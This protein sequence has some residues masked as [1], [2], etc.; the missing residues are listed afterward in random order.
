MSDRYL[1]RRDVERDTGL[2]RATIYR[3]MEA[4]LFPRPR[5]VGP[6][7]VRWLESDLQRWKAKHP[8]TEPR[9]G[10]HPHP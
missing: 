5:R 4:G 6:N 9:S 3:H 10:P 8:V 2:S 7:S 1:R